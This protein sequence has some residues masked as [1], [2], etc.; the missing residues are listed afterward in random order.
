MQKQITILGRNY[1]LR[2]DN[3]EELE[4]A[5]MEVDRRLKQLIGRTAGVDQYTAAMLTALNLASEVRALKR[6]YRDRLDAMER[7][8]AAIETVLA[9]A[10]AEEG[11]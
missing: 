10:V 4:A 7:E 1:T 11:A 2:A 6:G 9:A 8:A 3:G 5:A